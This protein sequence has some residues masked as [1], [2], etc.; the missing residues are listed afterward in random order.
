MFGRSN[1]SVL[2]VIDLFFMYYNS[3]RQCDV[4]LARLIEF[5]PYADWDINQVLRD[6]WETGF[7]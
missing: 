5:T 1:L 4:R 7:N 6:T 3:A 2:M